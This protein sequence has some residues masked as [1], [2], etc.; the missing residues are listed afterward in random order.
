MTGMRKRSKQI[1]DKDVQGAL[2]RRVI[3]HFCAFIVV[4]GL[5][6]LTVQFLSNPFQSF[7]QQS[8]NFWNNSGPYLV[9]LVL[10]LP[11]FVYDTIKLSNRIAGPVYR[12]RST[13]MSIKRGEETP[14]LKFRSVDFWQEMAVEF[15]E[16]V[17]EL[18]KREQILAEQHEADS[19][20]ELTV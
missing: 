6:G 3:V 10:M 18:K 13:M 20:A 12:L 2:A 1:V 9:A 4:G 5:L 16:M 11:I 15:N 19:P 14:E 7:E 8:T 17:T